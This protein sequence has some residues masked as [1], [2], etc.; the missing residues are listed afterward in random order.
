[1]RNIQKKIITIMLITGVALTGYQLAFA[2]G[3]DGGA[4]SHQAGVMNS[5]GKEATCG[6]GSH[7]QKFDPEMKK[8]MEMFMEQTVEIRKQL[9]M[10]R[11][12]KAALMQ[13]ETPDVAAVA[14]V[15]G[16]LFDLRESLR[17]QA[18]EAGIPHSMFKALDGHG[19]K[20]RKGGKCPGRMM[21]GGW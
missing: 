14:L 18:K 4:K 19:G 9:A 15:A 13:A 8:K 2:E 6:K 5:H 20:H 7:M 11:A 12:R 17:L 1:M 21:H 3:C 10:K 16:E